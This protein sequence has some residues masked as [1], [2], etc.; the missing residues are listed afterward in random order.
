MDRDA[1]TKRLMSLFLVELED[2]EQTLERDLL[3]LERTRAS[4]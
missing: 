2:H 1:L 4:S 3:A